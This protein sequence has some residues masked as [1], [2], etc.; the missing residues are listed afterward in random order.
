[1]LR[2]IGKWLIGFS[3]SLA[4][5]G[6]A[7]SAVP[8]EQAA[9]L[10][11][12][13]SP[14]SVLAAL[15]L[16]LIMTALRAWRWQLVVGWF[17]IAVSFRRSFDL[18]QLGNFVSQCVPGIIGGDIVRAWAAP[19]MACPIKEASYAI[20]ADRAFGFVALVIVGTVAGIIFLEDIWPDIEWQLS[21][22]ALMSGVVGTLLF[23]VVSGALILSSRSAQDKAR[24]LQVG[25]QYALQF[26]WRRKRHVSLLLAIS[27]LSHVIFCVM[28]FVLAYGLGVRGITL[29]ALIA[30][31]PPVMLLTMLPISLAGWGIREGAMMFALSYIGVP[32]GEAFA[33]SILIG[34]VTF[35][36][37]LHGAFVLVHLFGQSS[38]TEAS[39]QPSDP[40]GG[41][42][43]N[44]K[45]G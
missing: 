12:K 13:A 27:I 14:L 26:V 7:S 23:L 30:V 32:R 19:R 31:L 22:G 38:R 4:A 18:V 36:G 21:G 9:A 11:V 10:L 5:L 16:V 24:R 28:A 44:K 37:A 8:L 40:E 2:L 15:G 35:A 17:G 42:D 34:I 43:T 39:L 41:L 3:V 25:L 1:M 45:M 6:Y 20:I 33:V 29:F